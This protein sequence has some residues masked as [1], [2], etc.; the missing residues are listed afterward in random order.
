MLPN[1]AVLPVLHKNLFSVTQELQKGFQVTPEC[2]SLINRE[3][4]TEIR[5][6]MKMA[7]NGAKVFLLTTKFYKSANEADILA[8]ESR[9]P[10]GKAYVKTEGK[11]DKNQ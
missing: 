2:K 1:T 8:R 10:E 9:K 5:F 7:N 3:K 11:K 4:S 6:D